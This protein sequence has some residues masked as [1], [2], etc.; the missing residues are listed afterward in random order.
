MP[1]SPGYVAM[2][3]E[4]LEA[5]GQ[6]SVRRMFGGAGVYAESVMFAIVDDDQLYLK[7]DDAGAAL[8]EAEGMGPFTY[9]TKSGEGT[10][11]SY[12]RAPERLLD[13]PEEMVVWA[14]RALQVALSSAVKPA[15]TT[16]PHKAH[17]APEPAAVHPR[18]RS[19]PKKR[20]R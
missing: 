15:K 7:T 19:Q 12:W 11:K 14:R 6:V 5:L 8:F 18:K 13:E 10:L 2:L 17:A 1:V 9:R 3:C 4:L 20:S 16:K